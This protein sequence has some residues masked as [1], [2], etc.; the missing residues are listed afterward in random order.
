MGFLRLGVACAV[1]DSD[2]RILLSRRSDLNLW[3]LPGG[4]LDVGETLHD[5]VVRE[6]EEETGIVVR[7]ERPLG[8]YYYTGWTRLNILYRAHPVAGELVST[9]A[10][11]YDNRF[12]PPDDLPSDQLDKQT[13]IDVVHEVVLPLRTIQMP[14]LKRGSISSRLRWRWLKNMLSGK[15][16]P[17]FPLFDVHAVAVIWDR[18]LRRVLTLPEQQLHRLPR[19]HCDGRSTP[20]EHLTNLMLRYCATQL[21]WHW[22]GLWQDVTQDK[23][24]LVFLM[25]L[26]DGIQTIGGAEW[27]SA[28]NSALIGRDADYVERT[29]PRDE[30]AVWT[31][32]QDSRRDYIDAIVHEFI[33]L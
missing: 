10:E 6:V 28:Q 31:S 25:T 18:S 14:L 13:V 27:S 23:I 16:E 20:W 4:R 15:P 30:D 22:V 8:L 11:T 21:H 2:G 29:N 17:G 33:E 12:F 5:A 32:V 24:D 19:V 1:I 26:P 9:T 3:N 7:V